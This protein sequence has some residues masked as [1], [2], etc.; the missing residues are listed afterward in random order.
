MI[1]LNI[2]YVPFTASIVEGNRGQQRLTIQAAKTQRDIF[3][4]I[5]L[6]WEKNHKSENWSF[7]QQFG[8][9][10]RELVDDI[11]GKDKET[12]HHSEPLLVSFVKLFQDQ[13]LLMCKY[14]KMLISS[15]DVE[16]T[17]GPASL[18]EIDPKKLKKYSPHPKTYN[19]IF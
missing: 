11:I 10:V 14:D 17:E 2:K 4:A 7:A 3:Y 15:D 9:K 16:E 5:L 1:D 8:W 6:E 13:L 12:I 18:N 19:S